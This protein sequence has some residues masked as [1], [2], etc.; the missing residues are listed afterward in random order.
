[1]SDFP[2]IDTPIPRRG[3]TSSQFCKRHNIGKTSYFAEVRAKRLNPVRLGLKG[4]HIVTI[5]EDA[6]WFAARTGQ[7]DAA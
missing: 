7:G 2:S 1:M 5:E 4:K 6:R 3:F